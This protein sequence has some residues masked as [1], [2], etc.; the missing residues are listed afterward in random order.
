M[1]CKV[2]GVHQQRILTAELQALLACYRQHVFL[3][4]F[5]VLRQR[6]AAPV[7]NISCFVLASLQMSTGF[8]QT[9]Q[10]FMVV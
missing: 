5:V 3:G 7:P 2:L 9:H 1:V 6:G 10:A 8:E 4:F